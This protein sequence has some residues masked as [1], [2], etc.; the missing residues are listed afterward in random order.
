MARKRS[1]TLEVLEDRLTPVTFGIPWPAAERL[2]LSFAPDGTQIAGHTSELFQALNAGAAT[3]VWQREILRAFQ[4]WAVHANI[5][6]GVTSDGGQPFGVAGRPYAD[7][8][9]GDIRVGAHR[10]SPEALATSVPF[11]PVFS[12]T[13]T[14]DVFLNSGSNFS[15]NRLFATMLH[16]AGHVF[17]LGHSDNPA[18]PMYAHLNTLAQLTGGDVA[19]LRALYGARTPDAYEAPRGNNEFQTAA[20]FRHPQ[21]QPRP[22][23][24]STPLVLFGDVTTRNDADVFS[25][26]PASGYRGPVTIRLQTAGVS[27]LAPRLTVFDAARRELGQ[28]ASSEAFGATVSVRLDQVEPTASYFIRVEG[29]AGDVFGIGAYGL[30]VSHDAVGRVPSSDLERFLRG[31]YEGLT[32]EEIDRVL[33]DPARALVGNDRRNDDFNR[34][35][36]LRQRPG[37]GTV[38]DAVGSLSGAA[39]ADFYRVPAAP[40][41]SG[42]NPV[43]TVTAW[44][45]TDNA[46][47]PRIAVFASNRAPV[48][49]EVLVNGNGTFAVELAGEHPGGFYYLRLSAPPN[50]GSG[51]GNYALHALLNDR[52]ADLDTFASGALDD[53]APAQSHALYV[54]H[55]QLFQ[56]VLSAEAVGAPP[57]AGVRM[58]VFDSSCREVFQLEAP[59][60][61]TVSGP[62]VFLVPGAYTATFTTLGPAPVPTL[63]Y[64]LRGKALSDPVGPALEDPTLLPMYQSTGDPLLF[65]YPGNIQSFDHFMWVSLA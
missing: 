30:A 55:S 22:Y 54:A 47:V 52:A 23:D 9:F 34:A 17:G 11:A 20:P 10:M 6:V 1:L 61:D 51:A 56:F 2:T 14:G 4:T 41:Q 37:T 46:V 44:G 40:G 31:P 63:T 32:P 62:S 57:G 49:A 42:H 24:G 43:L 33:G 39:D 58:R 53:A 29:A 50:G 3:A 7:P 60:G 25:F 26:R 15:G 19:A 8:R 35:V 27:L 48:P 45:I 59:A 21:R 28:A 64:R 12:G 18:S 38:F 5:N 36:S 65:I 16:E 13:M